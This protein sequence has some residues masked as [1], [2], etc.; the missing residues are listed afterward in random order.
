MGDVDDGDAGLGQ[1]AHDAEKDLDLL[2]RERGGGLVHDEDL[3]VLLHEVAGY[4]DH[5]LL[6]DAQVA[7]LGV[8]RHLVLQP[9]QDLF[10]AL[11][12]G[13]VV[14]EGALFLLV[15]HVDVLRYGEVREEAQ[16]LVDDAYALRPGGGGVLERD[17]LAL[18]IE[19]AAG[20]LLDARDYLHQRALAGAVFADEHVHLAP[21]H[22]EGDVVERLG[23]GIY[24]FDLLAVQDNIRIVKHRPHLT[25][26]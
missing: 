8:G 23:A 15:V 2:V 6:A 7:H 20:G 24:L 13:G 3:E 11:D 25:G 21:Q 10:G 4:L 17:F 1:L 19:L 22:V 16:L 14:H 18:H 12:M 9:R 26:R 5:L